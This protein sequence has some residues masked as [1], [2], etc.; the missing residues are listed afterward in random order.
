L[1]LP[2]LILLAVHDWLH[3]PLHDSEGLVIFL[4]FSWATASQA[5]L[6]LYRV[7]GGSSMKSQALLLLAIVLVTTVYL[8]AVEQFTFFLYPDPDIVMGY[9]RAAALPDGLFA[10]ILVAFVLFVIVGWIAAYAKRHGQSVYTPNW[11]KHFRIAWYLFFVNRLYLDNVG[12]RLNEGVRNIAEVLGRH[13]FFFPIA[14][15][16]ALG[17]AANEMG[18]RGE[19]SF[20]WSPENIVSLFIAVLALPLFPFHG[21]YIAALTR[22]TGTLGVVL[23]FLMPA[24]GMYGLTVLLPALPPEILRGISLLALCGALYASMQTLV[25]ISVPHRV[26]YAGVAFYSILWWHIAES[27]NLKFTAAVFAGAA[28]L[29]AGGLLFAWDRIRVRYGD[30]DLNRI[31]GLARPMPPPR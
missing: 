27:G 9:Y 8:F 5:M 11:F 26:A 30:L 17:L 31:G 14:A 22:R 20:E 24:V 1:V 13:R 23:A 6:T 4:F 21:I 7:R 15:M 12:L 29:A 3:V 2:L 16:I 19:W 10:C 25:Q 18:W 28:T